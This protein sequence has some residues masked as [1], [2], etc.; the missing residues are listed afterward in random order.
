MTFNNKIKC[1]YS[2]STKN[3]TKLNSIAQALRKEKADQISVNQYVAYTARSTKAVWKTYLALRAH[4]S[5]HNSD[6]TKE[7]MENIHFKEDLALLIYVFC[8]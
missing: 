1:F 3:Q 2:F 8:H 4:F 6:S 7:K 5:K